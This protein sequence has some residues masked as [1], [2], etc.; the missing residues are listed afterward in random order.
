MADILIKNM[1][2]PDCC[3]YCVG[4]VV[5]A[6]DTEGVWKDTCKLTGKPIDLDNRDSRPCDCPLIELPPH[7]RLVDADALIKRNRESKGILEDFKGDPTLVNV[8][9]KSVIWEIKD[10]ETAPTVLEAST[11]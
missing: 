10:L 7:G 2:M 8:G 6:K 3:N 5:Y 4:M 1:E 11:E 9:Y